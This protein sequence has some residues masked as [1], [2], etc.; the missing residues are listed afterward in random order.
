ML[1][2]GVQ[3]WSEL[4]IWIPDGSPVR[5]LHETNADRAHAAGLRC[6]LVTQTVADTW[7]WLNSTPDVPNAS[8]LDP[9]R[10]AA[11]LDRTAAS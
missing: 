11:R 4:P 5:G 7:A 10:E 3:P 9:A 8:G 6:R 1:A 2:A